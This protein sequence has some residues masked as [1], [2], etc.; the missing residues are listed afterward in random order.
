MVGSA[1]KT[2]ERWM[3]RLREKSE[4]MGVKGFREMI[5]RLDY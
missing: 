2:D 1:Q 3:Q 5:M 4:K